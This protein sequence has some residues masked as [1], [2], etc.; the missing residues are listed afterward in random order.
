MTKITSPAPLVPNGRGQSHI[1]LITFSYLNALG[2]NGLA[3]TQCSYLACNDSYLNALG[4]N[5]LAGT[6]CSYLACN[7]SIIHS[8]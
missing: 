5:G 4:R 6:Q 7:D 8:Y 2:R 3:G 1:H